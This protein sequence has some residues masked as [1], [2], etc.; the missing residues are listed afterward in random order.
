MRVNMLPIYVNIFGFCNINLL[1]IIIAV[2]VQRRFR[3]QSWVTLFGHFQGHFFSLAL[4]IVC[5]TSSLAINY[6]NNYHL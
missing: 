4:P 5:L 3:L 2:V 1:Y 6:V